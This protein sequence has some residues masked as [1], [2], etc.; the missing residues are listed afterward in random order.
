[1]QEMQKK[2]V[3]IETTIPSFVTAKP[4]T[5]I[6]NLFRQTTAKTFWEYERHKYDLYT[7]PYV[8]EECAK[9][10]KEAAQRRLDLIKEIPQIP[11]SREADDLA[12]EYF[13][14]LKIPQRAKTDC[15]HLAICVVNKIDFLLSWNMTHLGDVAHDKVLEYN[16]KRNLWVPSL[17]DP[18][19]FMRK[20][21]LEETAD[22]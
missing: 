20:M 21:Q 9:G 22:V 16:I 12:E 13:E 17:L 5:D 4:T 1:M 7:S 10:D 11:K 19:T 15:S 8:W 6:G 3:Y 2:S 18:D 14:Y